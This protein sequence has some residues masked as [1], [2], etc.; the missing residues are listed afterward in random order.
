MNNKDPKKNQGQQKK[1]KQGEIPK[2]N[3]KKGD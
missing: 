1:K 3:K 2:K